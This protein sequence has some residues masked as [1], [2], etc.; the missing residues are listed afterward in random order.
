MKT[1]SELQKDVMAELNW[2]PSVNAAEIGVEVKDGVVTLAGHVDSYLEKWGAER[3]AQRVSGV[4]AMAVEIDVKLPW[5]SKKSDAEIAHAVENVLQ[6]MVYKPITPIKIMVENGWI[7][8]SGEV[9]WEYQRQAASNAVRHL[10]GV[11]GVSDQ[12]TLQARATS[13]T[14]KSEITAALNRSAKEDA[15]SIEVEVHGGD[16]TLSGKV[17]SWYERELAANSAWASPG[18][19]SVSDK[20]TIAY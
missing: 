18:V 11:T 19:K 4:K 8:L 15:K 7:T 13:N 20:I 3:V 1:D 14:I 9:A 5:S 2:E 16:V 17:N 6:W 12:I 10:M